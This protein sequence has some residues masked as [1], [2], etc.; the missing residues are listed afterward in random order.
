MEER[1]SSGALARQLIEN[2]KVRLIADWIPPFPSY[3]VVSEKKGDEN[4]Q[5]RKEG[6]GNHWVGLSGF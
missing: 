4:S 6:M 5:V 2:V 1:Y 3:F